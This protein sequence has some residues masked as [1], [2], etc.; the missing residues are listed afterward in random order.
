MFPSHAENISTCVRVCLFRDG[1]WDGR[2]LCNYMWMIFLSFFSGLGLDWVR[3]LPYGPS[4]WNWGPAN[5][6]VPE[7]LLFLC[8]GLLGLG[9][10][11][12]AGLPAPPGS[13]VLTS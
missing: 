8:P 11:A 3:V 9:L 12:G 2:D 7:G 6:G 1:L 4:C 10:P 5:A 13:L